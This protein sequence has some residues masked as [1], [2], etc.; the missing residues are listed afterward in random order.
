M[1]LYNYRLIF[2]SDC[3]PFT[4]NVSLRINQLFMVFPSASYAQSRFAVVADLLLI[5]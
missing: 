4:S 1:R 3:A 5:T 2:Y